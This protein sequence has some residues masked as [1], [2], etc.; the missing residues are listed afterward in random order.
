MSGMEVK[1]TV[2][3]SG[4]ELYGGTYLDEYVKEVFK[5]ELTKQIRKAVIAAMDDKV[6]AQIQA[7]AKKAQAEAIDKLLGGI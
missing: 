2:D 7:Y 5:D 6:K 3:L 4:L 1:F